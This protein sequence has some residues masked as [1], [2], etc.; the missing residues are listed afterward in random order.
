MAQITYRI[1][2]LGRSEIFIFFGIK[3]DLS[4]IMC[5]NIVYIK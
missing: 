2:M 1:T 3:L 4:N 5:Y